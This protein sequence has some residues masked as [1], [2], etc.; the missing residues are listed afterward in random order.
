MSSRAS[1]V[2]ITV[3]FEVRILNITIKSSFPTQAQHAEGYLTNIH[4]VDRLSAY[5]ASTEPAGLT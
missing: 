3:I 1:K 4:R 5:L 2:A